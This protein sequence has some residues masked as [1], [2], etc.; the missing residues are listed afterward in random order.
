MPQ[1]DIII[2]DRVVGRIT[3]D[4]APARLEAERI[5]AGFMLVIPSQ[6]ELAMAS[7]L[8]PAPM[9]SNL[10]GS[11]SVE[12]GSA[13]SLTLGIARDDRWYLGAVEQTPKPA[14]LTWV[15]SLAALARFETIRDGASPRLKIDFQG[16]A[17]WL[18]PPALGRPRRWRT[19]PSLVS[20]TV[21]LTYPREVWVQMLRELSVA[22]NV[23]VEIPLPSTP[24]SPWDGVWN[25][26]LEARTAFEQGGS[27]SWKACVSAARLALEKWE[28]IEKEDM[29]PGW[30]PPSKADRE[31]RTRTQR[32]DNLRWHLKQVVNVA[33]H[34]SAD[35][36]TRDDAL[37]SLATLSSLLA[38]RKP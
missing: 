14:S 23:L 12:S 13:A 2:D 1:I 10:R 22:E 33:P 17:C 16:E 27:T 21:R 28:G 29:G 15:G 35:V 38:R 32:L 9:L 37:L 31:S 11:I 8:D 26:L 18:V 34:E 3:F 5:A 7:T 4:E 20:G 25:A 36:W 30:T 19:E 6:V 24:P